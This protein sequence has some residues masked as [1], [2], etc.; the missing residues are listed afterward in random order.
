M[1][2]HSGVKLHRTTG[3]ER[4]RALWRKCALYSAIGLV[5]LIAT[6]VALDQV[7]LAYAS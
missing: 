5:P 2:A 4:I 6:V 7:N 3:P 1:T